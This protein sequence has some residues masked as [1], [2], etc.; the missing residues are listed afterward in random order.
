MRFI[1]NGSHVPSCKILF[2]TFVNC[3]MQPCVWYVHHHLQ[4]GAHVKCIAGWLVLNNI[5]PKLDRLP[6]HSMTC[7]MRATLPLATCDLCSATNCDMGCATS[8]FVVLRHPMASYKH[9]SRVLL[10]YLGRKHNLTVTHLVVRSNADTQNA[11]NGQ[12][13][14]RSSRQRMMPSFIAAKQCLGRLVGSEVQCMAWPTK[15]SK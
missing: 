9:H 12:V 10:L 11:K 2:R 8:A 15:S 5:A 13:T 4:N 3:K 7:K 1:W 6:S 14:C